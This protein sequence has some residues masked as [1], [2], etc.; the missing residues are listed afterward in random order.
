M[1]ALV[2][3]LLLFALMLGTLV[4]NAEY[5]SDIAE[6][7]ELYT[8][9]IP[10]FSENA[11]YDPSRTEELDL[12]AEFWKRERKKVSL[13]VTVRIAEEIDEKICNMKAALTHDDK[14]E[15]DS[16]R[17]HLLRIADGLRQ[18][19]RISVGSIL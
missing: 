4:L 1:K 16:S 10:S 15:F 3:S 17:E 19:D 9:S 18:Y 11:S 14:T 13:S 2:I 7:L 5:L 6:E 8:R 12:L